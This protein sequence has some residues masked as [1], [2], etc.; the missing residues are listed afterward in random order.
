MSS[1]A[2]FERFQGPRFFILFGIFALYTLWYTLIGPYARLI[3]LAP[4]MPLQAQGFYTGAYAVEVLS[5]LDLAGRNAAYI[6]YLFNVPYMIMQALVFEAVIVFGLKARRLSGPKWHL[7]L[8]LPLA[9]LIFDFLEDSFLALT[10]ATKS[11]ILGSFAG[12]FTALKFTAFI[13]SIF[14]SLWLGLRGVIAH[15]RK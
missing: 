4:G 3:G 5:Q 9:F 8:I 11:E 14:I 7:L 10:L 15:M 13:P 6:A 1:L 2:P 12:V